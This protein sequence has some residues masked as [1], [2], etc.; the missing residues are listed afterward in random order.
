MARFLHLAEDFSRALIAFTIEYDNDWE[1]NFW[2]PL[3][4]KP[5]RVSMVMWENFLRLVPTKGISLRKLASKAGYP[6]GKAHPCIAGMIRWRF[7]TAEPN[8]EGKKGKLEQIIKPTTVGKR[9]AAYWR[10]LAGKI[11]TRWEQRFGKNQVSELKQSLVDLI[12]QFEIRLPHYFPVLGH[13]DG[14]RAPWPCEPETLPPQQLM[15]PNLLS[16]AIHYYT[17]EF[18]KESEVSLAHRANVLRVLSAKGVSV[19]NVP[20]LAGVSKEALNMAYRFLIKSGHVVEAPLKNGRGKQ[21]KLT[22]KGMAEKNRYDELHQ[23]METKW[24]DAFSAKVVTRLRKAIAA[25]AGDK[26]GEESPLFRGLAPVPGTWRADIP[27]RLVLPRSPMVLNR[28]GW[29]DGS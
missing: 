14:M 9:A 24:Q 11:E 8:N 16:Q 26:T 22:K 27:P 12:D 10:T 7:V 5:L 29:P 3:K 25:I 18:E 6:K 21:V 15:L 17:L 2:L 13:L 1:K 4:A 19:N 23:A 20:A 28:G